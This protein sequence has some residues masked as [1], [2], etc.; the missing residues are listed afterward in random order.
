M[1]EQIREFLTARGIKF[2]EHEFEWREQLEITFVIN[3]ANAG[4]EFMHELE[5]A[6]EWSDVTDEYD[7]GTNWVNYSY[8]I[9]NQLTIDVQIIW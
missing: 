7:R 9:Y 1:R 4:Q 8:E 5:K 2:K 3:D 6:F